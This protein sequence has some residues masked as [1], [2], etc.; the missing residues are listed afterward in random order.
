MGKAALKCDLI[1]EAKHLQKEENQEIV[2]SAK[3][4]TFLRK[5]E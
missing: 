4:V 5:K 1:W 3:E 2:T